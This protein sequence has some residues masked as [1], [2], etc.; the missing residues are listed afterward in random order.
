MSSGTVGAAASE[1]IEGGF[2][3]SD[4]F[5]PRQVTAAS[6]CAFRPFMEQISKES[7]GS[8]PDP[9]RTPEN[10]KSAS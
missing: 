5:G 10:V 1:E 8:P 9:S 7:E 2:G 4:P 6:V 3:R